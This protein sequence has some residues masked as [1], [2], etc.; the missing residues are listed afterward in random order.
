MLETKH[1]LLF[2]Q[3]D[4]RVITVLCLRY[5]NVQNCLHRWRSSGKTY[6][7]WYLWSVT[8]F[9]L[10]YDY[11]M[12]ARVG[13]H[14]Y[15]KD[16]HNNKL[17]TLTNAINHVKND[18][19]S[20]SFITKLFVPWNRRVLTSCNSMHVLVNYVRALSSVRVKVMNWLFFWNIL[21]MTST[22]QSWFLRVIGAY[23]SKKSHNIQLHAWVGAAV[24]KVYSK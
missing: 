15:L 8:Q 5:P 22:H 24:L 14:V 2:D 4:R 18:I 21:F 17:R 19:S 13:T 3:F 12:I 9:H 16:E 6:I 10:Q 20:N 11:R 1:T 7:I 23:N